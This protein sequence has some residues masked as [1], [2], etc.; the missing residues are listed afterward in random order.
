M[1]SM[2]RLNLI[3]W[4]PIKFMP[5]WLELQSPSQEFILTSYFRIGGVPPSPPLIHR[6]ILSLGLCKAAQ[7]MMLP[8]HGK[9]RLNNVISCKAWHQVFTLLQQLLRQMAKCKN[10]QC[11]YKSM[12]ASVDYKERGAVAKWIRSE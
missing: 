5:I 4:V 6:W 2:I 12:M 3:F 9:E 10:D 8:V 7:S 1:V 11:K